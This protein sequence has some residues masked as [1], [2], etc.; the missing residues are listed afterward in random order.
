[1]S[2]KIILF[3][4]VVSLLVCNLECAVTTITSSTQYGTAI[5]SSPLTIAIWGGKRCSYTSSMRVIKK[6]NKLMILNI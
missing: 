6:K 4:L 1:M 2:M 3:C 5:N